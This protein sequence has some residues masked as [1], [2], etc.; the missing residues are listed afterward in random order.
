VR[1]PDNKTISGFLG[2]YDDSIAIITAF[3]MP[4]VYP[5]DMRVPLDLQQVTNEKR[6]PFAFGRTNGGR[7]MGTEC[8]RLDFSEAAVVS[9]DCAITE[10][11]L[12][13]P[14]LWFDR[15]GNG[16]FVGVMVEVH[17]KF[18]PTKVLDEKLQLFWSGAD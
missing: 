11:G 10:S 4:C 14:V 13:G 9:C 6:S 18:L 16:H 7:L 12:G 1:L 15:D 3:S 5:V 17:G 8:S 2:L